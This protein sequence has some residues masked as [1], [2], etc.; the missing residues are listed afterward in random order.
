MYTLKVATVLLTLSGAV[1]AAFDP[2]CAV[3]AHFFALFV[4]CKDVTLNGS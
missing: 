1:S 4:F 3:C 2:G